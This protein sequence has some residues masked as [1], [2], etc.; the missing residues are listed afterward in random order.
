MQGISEQQ[1]FY[2]ADPQIIIEIVFVFS[3]NLKVV[4]RKKESTCHNPECVE[5]NYEK[6]W[7]TIRFF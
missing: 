3:G 6:H 2:F 7:R 5:C 4:C 1:E